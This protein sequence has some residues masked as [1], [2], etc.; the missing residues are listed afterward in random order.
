MAK[1]FLKYFDRYKLIPRPQQVEVLELLENE[2]D[3]YDYFLLNAPTRC[4]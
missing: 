2:W 3:N 1:E 4:W